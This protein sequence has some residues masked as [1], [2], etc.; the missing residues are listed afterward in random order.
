[1]KILVI[2][3]YYYPEPFRITD[4]CEELVKQGHSVTVV[5]GTP[6]YPMGEIYQG[7]QNGNKADEII[8]GVTVHRCITAPRKTGTINRVRN[9]FSYP[10]QSKKYVKKLK[11][12]FDVVFVNQ[13]S[14]VM[15]AEAGIAYKRKHNKK[16]VLY[17]MDLWP[18]SLCIGGIKK[19]SVIYK[20]F[21]SISRKIYRAAD[22]ILVTSQSFKEHLSKNFSIEENKISYLPQYAEE[23]FLEVK[24]KQQTEEFNLLFAGNIGMAQSMETVISAARILKDEKILFHIVG[25]GSEFEKSKASA[26]D[27][28]NVIFYGRKPLEEMP[29]YYDMADAVLLTLTDDPIISLTLPGKVQAYMAAGRPIIGAIGGEAATLINGVQGGYCGKPED[30]EELASNIRKLIASGKASEIGSINRIYYKE[31]FSKEHFINNL[32]EHLK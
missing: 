19:G 1:M 18:E 25:D 15:M 22:S 11:D 16:L 32:C 29:K 30:A 3:Q 13:L 20:L 2:C 28:T 6:N 24:E 21:N 5:A 14:P 4:I 31:N 23:Q 9:Y 8:N 17:C 12:D 7:Y 10:R 26:V 27:L